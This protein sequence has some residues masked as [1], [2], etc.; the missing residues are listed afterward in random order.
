MSIGVVIVTHNNE[1]TI[2]PCLKSVEAQGISDICVVD[3]ASM[4][5]TGAVLRQEMYQ[6][7]ALPE[8]KGFSYAAN[9]GVPEVAGDYILFLNPDAEL[10]PG[11]INAMQSGI[12]LHRDARVVGGLLVDARGRIQ[13]DAYGDEIHLMSIFTRHM[14][15]K[16]LVSIISPAAWVSGGSLMIQ[17]DIF[18]K[19][20]GFDEQFFLYWEDVDL[21]RRVRSL[22]YGVYVVPNARISHLRGVSSK[23]R[24]RKTQLYD[25]SA[26]RYFQKYYSPLICYFQLIARKLYRLLRPLAR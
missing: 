10:L 16:R 11:A 25:A 1:Q 9:K 14:Q 3:S 4:D 21:C 20:G 17:R 8:N 7:I 15:T 23:D 5:T 22:G 13:Q 26:N 2:L 6:Y 12:Q 24:R 18:Q 19:I